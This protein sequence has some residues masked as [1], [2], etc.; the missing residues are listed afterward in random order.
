MATSITTTSS[1]ASKASRIRALSAS[2]WIGLALS[3]S[4]ARKRFG[5][6]VRIS[7]GMAFDGISPAMMRWPPTG[8][9][10]PLPDPPPRPA[11]RVWMFIPPWRA[12]LPVTR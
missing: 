10:F 11:I 1:S 2:E 12:K 6:S 5:W 4:A 8:L 9:A 7:S 3:T